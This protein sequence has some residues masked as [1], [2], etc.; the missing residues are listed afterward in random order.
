[1]RAY[2]AV[3]APDRIANEG[4]L[5]SR[6]HAFLTSHDHVD[7]E[8]EKTRWPIVRAQ[9]EKAGMRLAAVLERGLGA[10]R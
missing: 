7:A 3:T 5:L 6:K 2:Q 4:L 10:R 9:L 1:V 8:Y